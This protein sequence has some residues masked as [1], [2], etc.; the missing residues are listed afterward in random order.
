MLKSNLIIGI[1]VFA[2]V[3]AAMAYH[4]QTISIL[5]RD[6]TK[7]TEQKADL[8]SRLHAAEANYRKVSQGLDVMTAA[9]QVAIQ[10][11]KQQTE[12]ADRT[13][14]ELEKLSIEPLEP[15]ELEGLNEW[16]SDLFR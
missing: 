7:L 13:A 16:L 3:A 9:W 5:E 8:H 4:Y 15:I 12:R 10:D 6:K 11:A 1:G 2:I 14:K